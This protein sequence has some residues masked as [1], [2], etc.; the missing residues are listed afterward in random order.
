MRT[1]N[2]WA[3]VRS[4]GYRTWLWIRR[5]GLRASARSC[6][7]QPR[8]GR[9]RAA[10]LTSSCHQT[11]GALMRTGSTRGR[12]SVAPTPTS[13][14]LVSLTAHPPARPQRAPWRRE[15]DSSFELLRLW[16]PEVAADL[17]RECIPD[18]IVTGNRA[19]PA[20]NLILPPRMS[21]TLAYQLT[22]V[23]LQVPQQI[24]ALHTA[25]GNSSYSL[26]AALRASS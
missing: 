3:S 14:G 6:W 24:A 20:G 25:I 13:N 10:S 8:T 4:V 16:D 12:G 26:P 7:P 19:S 11:V 21:A 9:R 22:S 23:R 1:S 5:G 17:L 15:N 18:F 2:R